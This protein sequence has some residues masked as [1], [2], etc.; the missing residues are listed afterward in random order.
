MLIIHFNA[1]ITDRSNL[2]S[3][4]S[5]LLDVNPKIRADEHLRPQQ[6]RRLIFA[7]E[8]GNV[9]PGNR[10]P[11]RQLQFLLSLL[12]QRPQLR[13]QGPAGI[14]REGS[15]GVW[16]PSGVQDGPKANSYWAD[17]E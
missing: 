16:L 3:P 1:K 4:V 11:R 6:H 13:R 14:V 9:P 7:L 12:L 17:E 5:L 15:Q 2:N 8:L 10:P